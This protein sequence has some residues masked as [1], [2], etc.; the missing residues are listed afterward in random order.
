MKFKS[1]LKFNENFR[2][3]IGNINQLPHV[4]IG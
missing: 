4:K 3:I 1:N 2:E